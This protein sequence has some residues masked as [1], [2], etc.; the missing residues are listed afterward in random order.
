MFD[1]ATRLKLTFDSPKGLL[2]VQ[3][4]WDLPL[5]TSLPN[6][7]SL[8]SIAIALDAEIQKSGNKSFV[9]T[10]TKTDSTLNLKL[11]IVKHIIEFKVNENAQNKIAHD[12]K[13]LKEKI[14]GVIA[15]KR[16]ES[17]KGKSLEEL[18]KM[19]DTI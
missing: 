18:E 2:S 9:S 1:K 19:I 8:D 13:E 10:S 16:D 15:E 12:K 17:L 6:K 7:P 5:Q 4:L 11:D 3:D 14:L